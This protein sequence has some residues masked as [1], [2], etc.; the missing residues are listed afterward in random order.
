MEEQRREPPVIQAAVQ[1]E[2]CSDEEHDVLR[3]FMV[4]LTYVYEIDDTLD[5]V[6]LVR[7]WITWKPRSE[8]LWASGDAIST[9]AALLSARATDIVEAHPSEPIRAVVL[10]DRLVLEYPWRG[11]KLTGA[12]VASLIDAL[13]LERSETVIALTPEPLTA[14]GEAY[15]EGSERDS[16]IERLTSAYAAQGFERWQDSTVWWLPL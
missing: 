6:G 2:R 10:I 14:A 4:S 11:R 15:D 13:Q 3:D 16:A 5:Q 9:D 12:I 7:G 8:Q 1:I